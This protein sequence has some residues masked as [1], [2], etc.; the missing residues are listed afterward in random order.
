MKLFDRK[1]PFEKYSDLSAVYAKQWELSKFN[2]SIKN[3]SRI[4]YVFCSFKEW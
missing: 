1:T 2:F 3:Y 4:F